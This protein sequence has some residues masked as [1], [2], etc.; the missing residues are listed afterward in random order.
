MRLMAEAENRKACL[1]AE[2]EARRV[3]AEAE[4]ARLLAEADEADALA[5]L[6]LKMAYLETEE[7]LIAYSERGSSVA[8]LSTNKASKIKSRCRPPVERNAYNPRVK[9]SN[10]NY[11]RAKIDTSGACASKTQPE[12][13]FNGICARPQ[14]PEPS[15]LI[16]QR[17]TPDTK[18]YCVGDNST[19]LG[20]DGH[21][22]Q[23]AMRTGGTCR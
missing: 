21:K 16:Q 23:N 8:T 18:P 7:K 20:L 15:H 13:P 1:M 4:K 11:P 3:Q 10:A 12:N 22:R 14:K 19:N 2:A 6:R 5:N 9:S 17:Q